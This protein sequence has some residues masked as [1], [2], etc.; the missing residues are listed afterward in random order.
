MK[1]KTDELSN[2][3]PSP[4]RLPIIGNLNHLGKIPHRSL[5]KLPQKYGLVMLLQLG[6]VSNLVVSSAEMAKQVLR[7]HD[8]ECCSK[9]YSYG[10]MKLSYNL[11]DVAFGPYSEYWRVLRKICVIELFTVKRVQSFWNIREK[12]VG[13]HGR[14]ESCFPDFDAFFEGLI[15][16]H[17]DPDR[18]RPEHKDIID[19]LLEVSKD[20]TPS[21]HL[22]RDHIKSILMTH[23]SPDRDNLREAERI[24]ESVHHP[25][26]YPGQGNMVEDDPIAV[27]RIAAA[28][29]SAMRSRDRD[30]SIKIATKLGVKVFIGTSDPAVAKAWMIKIEFFM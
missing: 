22:S 8:L 2:L 30:F 29:V 1:P 26:E 15:D 28:V 23:I 4:P 25:S 21:I 9:P 14:L 27:E 18:L 13:L 12:G 6:Q 11:L 19:V 10:T 16:E 7:T 5:W 24:K 3:P 20:E 17:L